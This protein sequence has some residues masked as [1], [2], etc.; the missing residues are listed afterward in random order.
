[1]HKFGLD[2]DLT[3]PQAEVMVYQLGDAYIAGV[4]VNVERKFGQ[5]R[6]QYRPYFHPTSMHPKLA[7][8]LVNLTRVCEGESILDPFCGTGGI[9]IEA[10]LMGLQLQ[11]WDIDPKMVE[12][13]RQ[14][15]KEFQLR[16]D[17]TANDALLG[18]ARVDAIATDPPY[19]RSSYTS[20][21]TGS[22]IKKFTANARTL[23]DEG[24][25]M[26]LM[27]PAGQ[28]VDP[29]VFEI[30]E[31]FDVYIHK[32]LTRRLWVLEAI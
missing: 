20:E 14:N 1:L 28:K 24:S 17:I 11:G 4:K 6:A 30:R 9:L 7:R 18:T 29:H 3:N 23:L 27:T 10:G 32:S 25:Y 26:A 8:A 22:L 13:C 16:G 2:V 12:G 21:D 5:R 19:G 15:L 31:T